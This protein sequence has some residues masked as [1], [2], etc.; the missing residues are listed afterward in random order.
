MTKEN[1]K[2]VGCQSKDWFAGF[3]VVSTNED[4]E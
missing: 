4:S 1:E 2:Q 3:T